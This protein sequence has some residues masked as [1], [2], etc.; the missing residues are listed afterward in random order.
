MY[1][2]Y[3][4]DLDGISHTT[5]VVACLR[6]LQGWHH[7][8]IVDEICRFEPDHEDLP[9]IPFI[10]NYLANADSALTLP[11]PPYP[12]WL[13]P[14]H[15]SRAISPPLTRTTTRERTISSGVPST[16]S[17]PSL[18]F[19]HPLVAR[20]HP[21]M[22]VIFPSV[23]TVSMQSPPLSSSMSANSLS[24]VSP[25]RGRMPGEENQANVA[26][27]SGGGMV[28][29]EIL[30]AEQSTRMKTIRQGFASRSVMDKPPTQLSEAESQG[31]DTSMAVN[32][33]TEQPTR[34]EPDVEITD[35]FE[36]EEDEDED[37]EEDVQ[38]TSQYISALDL[39]GFG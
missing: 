9:L 15:L 35:E 6:K 23:A 31:L 16:S 20:K 3:L 12:T 4:A 1:P 18:P 13:W 37:E 7:D 11:P 39:A 30:H 28:D 26:S 34:M 19:P 10:T 24:R 36:D 21:T 14:T 33:W 2:L 27:P 22:R 32:G 5:L 25:R 17:I 29:N 8:S 38:P